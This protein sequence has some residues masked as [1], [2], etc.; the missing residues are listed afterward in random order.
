MLKRKMYERWKYASD[1]HPIFIRMYNNML[2]AMEVYIYMYLYRRY[3]TSD[4]DFIVLL[5][6]MKLN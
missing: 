4:R 6:K 3:T 1:I 2:V 5:Y